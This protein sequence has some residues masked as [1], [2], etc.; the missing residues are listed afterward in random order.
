MLIAQGKFIHAVSGAPPLTG[1]M[2]KRHRIKMNKADIR[3]L[4]APA[5]V[6][7]GVGRL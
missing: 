7:R 1:A 6:Y 5:P 4:I 3:E 2:E